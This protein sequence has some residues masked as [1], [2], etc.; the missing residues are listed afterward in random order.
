MPKIETKLVSTI[1]PFQ[2]NQLRAVNKEQVKAIFHDTLPLR[3]FVSLSEGEEKLPNFSSINLNFLYTMLQYGIFEASD[4]ES[5]LYYIHQRSMEMSPEKDCF[6]DKMITADCLTLIIIQ[7]HDEKM[8]IQMHP[9]GTGL[10]SSRQIF[11]KNMVS[12]STHSFSFSSRF[13]YA[14]EKFNPYITSILFFYLMVPLEQKERTEEQARED[15]KNSKMLNEKISHQILSFYLSNEDLFSK[16]VRWLDEQSIVYMGKGFG[17]YQSAFSSEA[18]KHQKA[19]LSTLHQLLEKDPGQERVE[20]SVKSVCAEIGSNLVLND[21]KQKRL[22]RM[23]YTQVMVP[24]ILLEL[25]RYSKHEASSEFIDTVMET[26]KNLSF[27]NYTAEVQLFNETSFVHFEEFSE[28]HPAT[29]AKFMAKLFKKNFRGVH[30]S[31]IIQDFLFKKVQGGS[32]ENSSS[33]HI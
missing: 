25:I 1:D 16:S 8:A 4:L 15:A 23:S 6:E 32:E 33:E 5:V 9:P 7:L 19:L 28:V 20:S 29:V 11:R 26:I 27:H 22:L 30:Y 10:F 17:K 24:N 14:N 18:K 31:S 21:K 12:G 2:R 3:K 13:F